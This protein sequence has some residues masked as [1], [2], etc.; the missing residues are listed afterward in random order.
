MDDTEVTA[1]AAGAALVSVMIGTNAGIGD[2]AGS[3]GFVARSIH[4]SRRHVKTCCELSCQRRATSETRAPGASVS[5]MIRAFSSTD[6]R[7]RRPGLV[8]SSIR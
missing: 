6:H 5:S 1:D 3:L 4:A 2:T 7:R 8:S